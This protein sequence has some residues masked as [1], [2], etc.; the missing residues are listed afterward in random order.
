MKR[1]LPNA[2]HV[3][4]QLDD[5]VVPNLRLNVTDRAVYSHLL[6]HTRLECRHRLCFSQIWLA[7]GIGVCRNT[8]RTSLRRLVNRGAVRLIENSYGG[9]VVEVLLPE[10]IRAAFT[11]S[12]QCPLLS[13][14]PK[15]SPDARTTAAALHELDFFATQSL[16]EAIYSR[17]R[18]S[19]F[20]CLRPLKKT[21][22]CLDHVIPRMHSGGNSYRNLVACCM[23]CNS[24]KAQRSA[25]DFLC[26]LFRERRLT[27]RLLASRLRALEALTAGKLRPRLQ[28]TSS[29]LD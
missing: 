14:S 7:K 16:R 19:C 4:K 10:E 9:H 3:W 25:A 20:Y 26:S 23:E 28:K 22:R 24:R 13:R 29:R 1:K 15:A 8:A 18:N 21:T 2:V 27:T 11:A 12:P 5:F 17:D 6:R